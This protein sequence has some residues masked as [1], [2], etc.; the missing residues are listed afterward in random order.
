[1]GLGLAS[2]RGAAWRTEEKCDLWILMRDSRLFWFGL[3]NGSKI[4]EEEEE[5]VVVGMERREERKVRVCVSRTPRVGVLFFC[6]RGIKI[7]KKI[8][9]KK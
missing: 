6:V 8:K 7:K 4:G 9:L 2:K 1:M 5:S 3:R